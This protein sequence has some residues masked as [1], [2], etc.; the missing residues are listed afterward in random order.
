MSAG[1]PK[2]PC[3]GLPTFTCFF[4]VTVQGADIL[5]CIFKGTIAI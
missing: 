3:T 4:D 1:K 2:K 5:L